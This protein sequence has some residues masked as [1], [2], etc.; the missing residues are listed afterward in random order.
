MLELQNLERAKEQ[1]K[2]GCYTCVAVCGERV[3]TSEERGVKPLLAWLDAEMNLQGFSVADKV[4]GKGA[5][6]LYVL[7]KPKEIYALVI[8]EPARKTLEKNGIS[9]TFENCVS[10]IRNRTN[11]GRCPMEQAVEEIDEPQKALVAIRQRL[12]E[13]QQKNV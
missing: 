12:E 13:L 10:E 2:N 3:L 6:M 9:V 1:L 7:L 4:I 11:T 5:A 8:S